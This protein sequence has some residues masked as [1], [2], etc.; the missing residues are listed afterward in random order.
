MAL[1]I[2]TSVTAN[3][4]ASAIWYFYSVIT[5]DLSIQLQIARAMRDDPENFV[6]QIAAVVLQQLKPNHSEVRAL[7]V[8]AFIKENDP[9]IKKII[10]GLLR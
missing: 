5:S 10:E 4:R 3:V 2:E 7:I 8:D 9:H 1:V 6:R